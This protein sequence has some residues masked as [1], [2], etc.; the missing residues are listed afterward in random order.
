MSSITARVVVAIPTLNAGPALS[1][2]LVSLEAQS[3]RDFA[4]VVIDNSGKDLAGGLTSTNFPLHI[5]RNDG[6]VGFGSAI[7]QAIASSSGEYVATLNDDC[8]ASPEWLGELVRV[9]DREYEIGLCAAQVLLAE[10]GMI[11]SVGMVI[12]RDGTSK[13]RGFGQAPDRY[14]KDSEVLFPSGC[15]AL[16]RRDMLSDVGGFDE[17]LFLYCEDTDLGLRARW[18]GW[19]AYYAAKAVVKHRYSHSAGRSSELKAL[20]VERNR[21]TTAFK[22]FPRRELLV[23]PIAGPIR[24]FFH[25]IA[26]MLGRGITADFN[27]QSPGLWRFPAILWKA[28]WHLL[29]HWSVIR[30]KRAAIKRRL[31]P[32]QMSVLLKRHRISLYAVAS[33]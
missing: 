26:L 28:H 15:S 11:D 17:S 29:R 9:A 33:L 30:K 4:V 6:N 12:A 21:L 32:R 10:T 22:N 2:C 1:E 13:Q 18:A 20:L 3:F 24:Y 19:Q 7:N 14:Q 5:I 8:V 23:V 27:R 25:L 31:E 16:Y